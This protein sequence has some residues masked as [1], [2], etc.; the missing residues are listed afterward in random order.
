MTKLIKSGQWKIA[1]QIPSEN[2]LKDHYKVS[3]LTIR[4]ALE[5]LTD[6]NLIIKKKGSRAKVISRKSSPKT[7]IYTT[8]DEPIFKK[9][10]NSIILDFTKKRSEKIKR[11]MNENIFEIKRL[12]YYNKEPAYIQQGQVLVR[13]VPDLNKKVFS[14]QK[15][16]NASLSEILVSKYNLQ[17][18]SQKITS[19]SVILS[20]EE[21]QFFMVPKNS[22]ATQW[23]NYY[24]DN[25]QHLLFINKEVSLKKIYIEL[26]NRNLL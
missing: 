12:F 5:L 8:L 23:V 14:L 9:R 26:Y 20:N 18:Y 19:S 22:A 21:A 2:F 6:E 24:Y 17:I 1:E 7:Y 11:F 10:T 15:F 13:T 3:R 4:K 16:S 25:N